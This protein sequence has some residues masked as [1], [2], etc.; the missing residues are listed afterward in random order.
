MEEKDFKGISYK[1]IFKNVN[2]NAAMLD[3][4][5]ALNS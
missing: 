1:L 2:V 4:N 5:K 3:A